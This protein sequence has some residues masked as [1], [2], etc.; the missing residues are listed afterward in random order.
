MTEILLA[1][2]V[3]PPGFIDVSVGEPHVVREILDDVFDLHPYDL[4]DVKH[5]HEYPPPHGHE[6]LVRL[7]E[8]K[9]GAPVVITNGAKQALGATFYALKQL[10]HSAINMRSPYWAL[11]PPLMTMHGLELATP[12]FID[13]D[14]NPCLVLAPNNPDGFCD[15]NLLNM[16][17]SYAKAGVPLIHDAAYYTHTYLPSDHALPAI[18]DVQIYSISKMLGLSGLR[19]GYAVC[20]NP[21][22]YRLITSYVEHMTV[23][24]SMLSQ[25]FTYDLMK[26][27]RGYPTL[28]SNFEGRS[29]AALQESKKIMMQVN[30]E[31][32]EV[33]ANLLDIPGMFLW[34][35]VGPKANFEKAKVNVIRGDLFGGYHDHVRINLAFNAKTMQDIVNKLNEAAV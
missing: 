27:M 5:M 23:G 34:A 20:R 6:P 9:H 11:L 16:H 8:E 12:E 15:A 28:T 7:L 18:G 31:V 10:G 1:K 13:G 3:L 22:F 29:F 4:P 21:D 25:I 26:R 24:A 2:P 17:L 30:P 14:A 35:K 33:P 32:L 19:I